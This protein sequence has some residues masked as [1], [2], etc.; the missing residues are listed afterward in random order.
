MAHAP[1]SP[2]LNTSLPPTFRQIR[3]ELARE[4]GHPDGDAHT[5]YILIAPLDPEA[6]IDAETWKRHRDACRV[7]R[8]RRGER[9]ARGHL[10][11]RRGG[12]S[13]HYDDA[14]IPDETGYHFADERFEPGEYVSIAEA[15]KTHAF[16][17]VSVNRL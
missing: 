5:A 6:R 13:F 14:S 12:W 7:I 17:V 11:H 10:V 8:Q 15:G 2:I 4:R 16:R 9:D 1:Q 3:L